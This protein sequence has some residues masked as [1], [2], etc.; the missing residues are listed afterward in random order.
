[1]QARCVR[2]C[3]CAGLMSLATGMFSDPVGARPHAVEPA[4]LSWVRTDA[5]AQCPG[6]PEM[7]STVEGYLGAGTLVAMSRAALVV[8]AAI[9]ARP[10]GGFRVGIKLVRAQVVIGRRELES[11]DQDCRRLAEE[12]ALAI[13]LTIDPEAT[14]LPS[15]PASAEQPN[16]PPIPAP[17][18][19]A[20]ELRVAPSSSAPGPAARRPERAPQAW[21][22]DLELALGLATGIVP[23]VG[24]GFALRGRVRAPFVALAL[25]VEGGYFAP[26]SVELATGKGA[27]FELLF[28]GLG[29]CNRP[30]RNAVIRLS[31][32]VGLDFTAVAAGAFGYDKNPQLWAW[33]LMFAAQ[34]RLAFRPAPGV[35]LAIG[36]NVFVPTGRDYFEAVT[37]T[38]TDQLFRMKAVGFGFELGGIWEL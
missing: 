9:D 35:A 28:A 30:E 29:L 34:G 15:R 19:P 7:A 14:G 38:G 31:G 23:R 22:G 37:P 32:C 25:Q 11:D 36:P 16:A 17:A 12:A 13:A 3:C 21:Q 10:G 4:A 5:A 24:P 8:E 33:T 27:N 20:P 2:Q 18:I 1:L 26:K 6:G